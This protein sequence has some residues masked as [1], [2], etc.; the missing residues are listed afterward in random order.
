MSALLTLLLISL[1]LS[2]SVQGY[3]T[4]ST[5][6]TLPMSTT[7][8]VSAPNAR[9]SLNIVWSRFGVFVACIYSIVHMKVLPRAEHVSIVERR[10]LPYHR[11]G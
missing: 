10:L 3:T 5:N 6:C 9:G 8:Y 2:V 1:T 4:I 11:L 7:N